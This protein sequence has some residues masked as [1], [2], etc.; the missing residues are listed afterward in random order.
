MDATGV[1]YAP[2]HARD[3]AAAVSQIVPVFLL[4]A[5]AV[6]LRIRPHPTDGDHGHPGFFGRGFPN[7]VLTA[8]VIGSAMCTEYAALFGVISGGLSRHDVHLL[9]RLLCATLFLTSVRILAPVVE[10]YADRTRSDESKVWGALAV[11]A[12]AGG[13]AMLF[14][15][16]TGS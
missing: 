3:L 10:L 7:L 4:A 5:I 6:P 15:F 11:L 13:V 1:I 12:G 16:N 9:E 2:E 14:L 8:L